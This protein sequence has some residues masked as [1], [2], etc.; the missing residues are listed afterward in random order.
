MMLYLFVATPCLTL[1][2]AGHLFYL[3]Q[4][5]AS[6]STVDSFAVGG[7][8]SVA[9]WLLIAIERDAA[10]SRMRDTTQVA[11]TSIGSS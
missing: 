7:A 10:F 2:T 6:F 11:W 9:V 3:F 4:G 1:L 8:A 5:R